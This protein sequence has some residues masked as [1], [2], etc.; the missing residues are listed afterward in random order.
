[1]IW[2]RFICS[3]S[4]YFKEIMS[5]QSSQL[6]GEFFYMGTKLTV[7]QTER[8]MMHVNATKETS[9]NVQPFLNYSV[10]CERVKFG[11]A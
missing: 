2:H 7:A 10:H 4:Y 5:L 8:Q 3:Q 9:C 6:K 11:S 1:M